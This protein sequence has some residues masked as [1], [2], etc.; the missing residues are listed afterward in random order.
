MTTAVAKAH[1]QHDQKFVPDLLRGGSHEGIPHD[2]DEGE[3]NDEDDTHA[4][5]T[6]TAQVPEQ[7]NIV[8]PGVP[9]RTGQASLKDL[10]NLIVLVSALRCRSRD[11]VRGSECLC[12]CVCVCACGVLLTCS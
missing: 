6:S 5:A 7:E 4:A 12:V 11:C 3:D 1:N 10:V 2:D 9:I 8:S